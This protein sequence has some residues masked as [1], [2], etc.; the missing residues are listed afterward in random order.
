[1][2]KGLLDFE[3]KWRQA[4]KFCRI[5]NKRLEL[6][7]ILRR[8]LSCRN[9]INSTFFHLS[10]QIGRR[11]RKGQVFLLLNKYQDKKKKSPK[12]FFAHLLLDP[13]ARRRK[14]FALRLIISFGAFQRKKDE[15]TNGKMMAF[16][17]V[18]TL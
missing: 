9:L 12:L 18:Y 2:F 3:K 17:F 4:E 5:G 16:A 14:L 10:K 6:V 15:E 7:K 13:F 1:M 11:R 8:V